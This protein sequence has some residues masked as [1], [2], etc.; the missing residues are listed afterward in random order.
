MEKFVV[1]DRDIGLGLGTEAMM[2]KKLRVTHVP[3]ER[4]ELRIAVS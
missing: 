4:R 2:E 1:V 3:I